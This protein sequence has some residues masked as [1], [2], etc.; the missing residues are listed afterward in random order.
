MARRPAGLIS[1][2]ELAKIQGVSPD[3]ALRRLR[4]LAQTSGRDLLLRFGTGKT[5]AYYTTRSL[6]LA[7]DAR[8]LEEHEV[9]RSDVEDLKSWKARAHAEIQ[10]IRA[11]LRAIEA[12]ESGP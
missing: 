10:R 4:R 3:T 11:R 6:L 5:A 2:A 1:V 8:L 12:L 7:A 9:M